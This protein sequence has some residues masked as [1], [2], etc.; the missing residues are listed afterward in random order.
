MQTILDFLKDHWVG[1]ITGTLGLL[2]LQWVTN[3]LTGEKAASFVRAELEKLRVY[4]NAHEV[5][6]QIQADDALINICEAAIP[7]VLHDLGDETH[8]AI[9]AGN[10]LAVDW[11]AFGQKLYGEVKDQVEG[12]LN[13]YLKTSSFS[14]GEALA[15]MIAKKFFITQ[16][17]AA[18]GLITDAPRAIVTDV[19]TTTVE[20]VKATKDTSPDK[21]TSE[22]VHTE[23]KGA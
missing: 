8:Q 13:N 17:M 12:G 19:T 22:A 7:L 3:L 14:D 18:K 5:M 6:A 10:I 16:K 4:S 23:V 15:A 9:A 21:V 1:L 20:T 2:A 11:K